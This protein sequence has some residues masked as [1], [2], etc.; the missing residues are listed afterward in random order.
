MS[1]PNNAFITL[2]YVFFYAVFNLRKLLYIICKAL[3]NFVK[4]SYNLYKVKGEV[5]TMEIKKSLKA[6]DI[7]ISKFATD[8]GISRPTLDAYIETFE[9]GQQISNETYQRIFEYLFDGEPMSS[10]DFVQKFDYVKRVMLNSAKASAEQDAINQREASVVENIQMKLNT[11]T[12]EKPLAEFINLFLSNKQDDLVQAIYMYF[13]YVNGFENM[14]K[15]EISD[16]DK[17]F[18][19]QLSLLFDQY[20]RDD[21]EMDQGQYQVVLEKNQALFEKKKVKINDSDIVDYIKVNLSDSKGIDL[22]VLK[23]MIENMEASKNDNQ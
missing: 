9:K 17:A 12:I 6:L 14:S 2:G 8:L 22:D 20:K 19:S 4:F 18:F 16:K 7:K 11:G 5:K 21:I 10:I 15:D 13:N 1:V 3:D 23:E